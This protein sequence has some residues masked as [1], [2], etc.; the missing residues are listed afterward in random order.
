MKVGQTNENLSADLVAR[1]GARQAVNTPTQANRTAPG[2]AADSQVDKVIV[3]DASRELVSDAS[4]VFDEQKV[5][6]AAAEIQNG[7]FRIDA[8]KIADRMINEAAELFERIS[9]FA[10][11]ER[12]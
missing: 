10:G 1:T 9:S 7:N 3:S 5:A 4:T 6:A 12:Q 11:G 8:N 2:N